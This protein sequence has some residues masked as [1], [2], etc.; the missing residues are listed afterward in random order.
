MGFT[1]SGIA[2]DTV[3]NESTGGA[4]DASQLMPLGFELTRES[5]VADEGMQT[6]VYIKANGALAVGTVVGRG[7]GTAGVGYKDV[8]P[9]ALNCPSSAVVGVVVKAIG[10]NGFGFIMK[11]G[12]CNVNAG[13]GTIDVDKG[14]MVENASGDAGLAQVVDANTDDAFGVAFADAADTAS[15]KCYINCR[16]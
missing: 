7:A 2:F 5:P 1:A 6:W 15:A 12:I 9:A 14:I 8:I 3:T 16:G 10:D 11:K 4:D 13:A